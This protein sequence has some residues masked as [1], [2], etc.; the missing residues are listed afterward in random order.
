MAEDM[1][2]FPS[3][4]KVGVNDNYTLG[5]SLGLVLPVTTLPGANAL[6]NI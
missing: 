2:D 3:D 4:Q 5:I 1:L 6:E